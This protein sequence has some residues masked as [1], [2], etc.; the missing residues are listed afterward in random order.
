MQSSFVFR[1]NYAPACPS[2]VRFKCALLKFKLTAGGHPHHFGVSSSLV[3][4]PIFMKSAPR[5]PGQLYILIR[6]PEGAIK[7]NTPHQ[8]LPQHFG[9]GLRPSVWSALA[10]EC[11]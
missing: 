7:F 1:A 4:A 8:L 3:A 5:P 10:R 9:L 11:R 6:R 2:G